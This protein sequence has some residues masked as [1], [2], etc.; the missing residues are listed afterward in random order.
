MVDDLADDMVSA[1]VLH[2]ALLRVAL[3]PLSPS[4]AI[5][6]PTASWHASALVGLLSPCFPAAGGQEWWH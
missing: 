5:P 1:S 3:R 4:L 2:W 6:P